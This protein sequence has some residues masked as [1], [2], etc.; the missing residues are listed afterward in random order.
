MLHALA[1]FMPLP[2]RGTTTRPLPE[3][4]FNGLLVMDSTTLLSNNMQFNSTG[5]VLV[6]MALTGRLGLLGMV[7]AAAP[8]D[9]DVAQLV[10][11]LHRALDA[12]ARVPACKP[13]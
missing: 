9:G 10:V 2:H 8:V 1:F 4:A 3:G 5:H 11:E 13:K 7:Q 12:S 6:L